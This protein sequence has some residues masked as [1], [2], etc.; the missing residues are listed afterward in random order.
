VS[1]YAD[2][3][4]DYDDYEDGF[5]EEPTDVAG[6]IAQDPEGYAGYEYV[7][8]VAEAQERA[9]YDE[10]EE[11]IEGVIDVLARQWGL[12]SDQ[13]RQHIR[14]AADQLFAGYL[15]QL[16]REGYDSNSLTHEQ[17]QRLASKC[18]TEG[19]EQVRDAYVQHEALRRTG[20]L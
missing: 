7:D 13:N 15:E 20:Q 5:Y 18:F 8:E 6:A 4:Y 16:K 1:D 3:Y 12:Q 11:Q 9:R 19:A 17:V 2:E 10:V 14:L